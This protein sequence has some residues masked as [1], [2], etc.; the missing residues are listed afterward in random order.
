MTTEQMDAVD[1]D[2]SRRLWCRWRC[3]ACGRKLWWWQR[4]RSW[5]RDIMHER[6]H[7]IYSRAMERSRQYRTMDRIA[8]NR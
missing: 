5:N 4:V 6:C 8:P 3:R 2:R 1:A 7:E